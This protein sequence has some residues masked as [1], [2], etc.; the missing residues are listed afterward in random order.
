MGGI[1]RH[2][3][4]AVML[5]FAAALLH[6]QNAPAP[7]AIAQRLDTPQVRVY[8]ATLQPHTPSISR[9]GHATNRVLIYMDD[10]AMSVKD[11]TGTTMLA[12]KRGEEPGIPELVTVESH[13][14]ESTHMA[15]RSGADRITIERAGGEDAAVPANRH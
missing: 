3:P 4:M 15:G 11:G 8:I 1:M 7:A 10:G 2:T 5:L 9:N 6:A 12:F 14:G 13:H